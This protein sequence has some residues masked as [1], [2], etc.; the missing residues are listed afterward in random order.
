VVGVSTIKNLKC[1]LKFSFFSYALP[2]LYSLFGPRAFDNPSAIKRIRT[3][4]KNSRMCGGSTAAFLKNYFK[5]ASISRRI[6]NLPDDRVEGRPEVSLL[7][8]LPTVN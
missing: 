8:L 5:Y 4:F 3:L 6:S 1:Y 2:S 7:S